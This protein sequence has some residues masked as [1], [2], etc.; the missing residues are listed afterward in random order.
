MLIDMFFFPFLME[1]ENRD[2]PVGIT[3]LSMLQ[4][5]IIDVT[6]MLLAS[7]RAVAQDMDV[8][9]PLQYA[10]C[11]RGNGKRFYNVT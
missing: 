9:S 10:I 1:Y 2:P 5:R 6:W 8:S 11:K 7:L 4:A 3:E